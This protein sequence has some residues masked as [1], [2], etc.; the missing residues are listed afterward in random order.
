M[1]ES[2]VIMG[3]DPGVKTGIALY[4]GGKLCELRTIAPADYENVLLDIK[5]VFLVLEDSRLTSKVFTEPTKNAKSRL[6][7]ARNI[8]MVDG[9]CHLLFDQCQRH[10]IEAMGVAPIDKGRKLNAASFCRHTRYTG[11]SNQHERD[12][13]MVAWPF[14]HRREKN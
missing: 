2:A 8:G 9:F 13:A 14:R 11:T 5:P 4:Q 6:K 3:I 10:D 7:I 1:T 12:A